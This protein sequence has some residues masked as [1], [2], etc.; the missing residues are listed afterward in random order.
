MSIS[1][2]LELDSNLNSRNKKRR[3][4]KRKE[5]KKKRGIRYMGRPTALLGPVN[6]FT[7]RSPICST[8]RVPLTR[9]T[10]A[11]YTATHL[12]FGCFTE[13]LGPLARGS[14]HARGRRLP[15]PSTNFSVHGGSGD[16][17]QSIVAPRPRS[18]P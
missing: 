9:G 17:A 5:K 16:R 3:K 6:T 8:A 15:P 10:R 14:S 13:L 1:S 11:S 2:Q 4:Q 18:R 12:S 7:T